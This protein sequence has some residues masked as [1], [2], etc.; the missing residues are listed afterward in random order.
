MVDPREKNYEWI[1]N[2]ARAAY[3]DS[4]GYMPGGVINT[5][6]WKM[7]EIKMYALS[8]QSVDKYKKQFSP[9][10][11]TDESW[12]S[13]DWTVP[14]FMAKYREIAISKILQRQYDIRAYAVD[15]LAKS[16]EDAYF[17]E[18]KVKVLM[19]QQAEQAGIDPNTLPSL[20]QGPDDPKDMEQL[21][22]QQKYGY[23][24]I[25]AMEA[26]NAISLIEQQNNGEIIRRNIA[27]SLVDYGVGAKTQLIDENGMVKDFGC[28]Y[29]EKSDFSDMI[30]WFEIVPTYVADL[31]PYYTKEQLDQICKSALNRYGNPTQ[32]VPYSGHFNRAWNRFKVM[33]MQIKF[34]SW[35]ETVYEERTDGADNMRVGKTHYKNRQFIVNK[36][37][38]LKESVDDQ[39]QDLDSE[40]YEDSIASTGEMGQTTPKFINDI[41]KVVYKASWIVNTEFMHNWGL[42][43]NQ[44]RKM[45]SWWDTDLDIQI[46]AWNFHKMQFGGLTERLIPLED[47]ACMAWFNLQNLS[48]KLIP[49]LINIDMT[50]VEAAGFG[51]GGQK[52][53][54]AA[55]VDF[56]FSNFIVPYRAENLLSRNPNYKP[57]TIEQTGQLAA[58][59]QLYQKLER[60]LM[61]MQQVSGLNE[62]TDASTVN[63]KNLN[64]TN[65]A[66]MESTNNALYPIMEADKYI[67]LKSADAIVQKVQIA[68]KLG[69]IEG[70]AKALGDDSVK[71]LSINP[72]ISLH[73]LGIFISEAPT[74]IEREALWKDLNIKESQGLILP[75][76]KYFIMKC[77][78]LDQA[79]M[80]LDYKIEKR[81]QEAHDQQMQL[82]A[83]Q[84]QQNQQTAAM[85]AKLEQ[86]TISMQGQLDIQKIIIEKKL[87]YEIEFMKKQTDLQGEITQ[88]A[89]RLDVSQVAA[90]AKVVA[91]SIASHGSLLETHLAGEKA[92]EKQEIANKKPKAPAKK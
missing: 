66:M 6:T 86:Q 27:E 16:D 10:N 65:A 75:G 47:Q 31:A 15:P 28:S 84:G 12:R 79:T 38:Q 13:I 73:E 76:D 68:V 85:T 46:F 33:V 11:P 60:T 14:A 17:N 52:M 70:Y 78:N 74:Q 51:K 4:F 22:M 3:W 34:L 42:K 40:N 90:E 30:H 19:R 43:E 62:V 35:N 91:Q 71:F 80:I 9:G 7:N 41:S 92:K 63:A 56:I 23:K 48:N 87:D 5:G 82:V 26:E 45:S 20:M 72:D 18:M 44:N 2:Y 32:Y 8:K 83:Q 61:M 25:M 59:E 67:V 77:R 54:P 29:C 57:V 53:K 21:M 50:A 64:S 55:L 58:F 1:M 24:H 88:A 37:G 49:Y 81:K 39:L 36:E 69:K 89:G